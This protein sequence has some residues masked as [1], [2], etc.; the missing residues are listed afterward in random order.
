M[1]QIRK[2]T[3]GR[4][5]FLHVLTG[6]SGMMGEKRHQRVPDEQAILL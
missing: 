3:A 1:E 4:F 6:Q 2:V 5:F